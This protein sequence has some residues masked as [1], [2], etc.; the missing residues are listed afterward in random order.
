[1]SSKLLRDYFD[2]FRYEN[3]EYNNRKEYPKQKL[4]DIK[5]NSCCLVDVYAYP[6]KKV[7]TCSND[8]NDDENYSCELQEEYYE[9]YPLLL[10]YEKCKNEDCINC[11]EKNPIIR[12]NNSY[13]ESEYV[14]D[15]GYF[16]DNSHYEDEGFNLFLFDCNY[17]VKCNK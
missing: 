6:F 12:I 9:T 15:E 5:F 3:K 13:M 1:M 11:E 16:I 8:T 17:N 7:F 4:D 2:I 10:E 14:D